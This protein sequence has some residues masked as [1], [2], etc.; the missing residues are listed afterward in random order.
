M[1]MNKPL[2]R[3]VGYDLPP[4]WDGEPVR[5]KPWQETPNLHICPLPPVT[6]TA[7]NQCG[8]I[9]DTPDRICWG[10]RQQAGPQQTTELRTLPSG[11]QYRRT[12][13][14][15]ARQVRDLVAFR[16]THCGHDRVWDQRTDQWWD[17]GPE[18]YTST[19]SVDPTKPQPDTL[20]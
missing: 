14:I 19:G 6:D 11:N 17:L 20:F 9:S 12:S 15:P 16:C 13:T 18:D 7:C 8:V 2:L 4:T 3:P 10:L 1:I 5:W